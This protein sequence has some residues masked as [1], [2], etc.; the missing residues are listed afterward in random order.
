MPVVEE[1]KAVQTALASLGMTPIASSTILPKDFLPVLLDGAPPHSFTHTHIH[2]AS[3]FYLRCGS[4]R[5]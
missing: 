4:W 3:L 1:T 5:F 2:I